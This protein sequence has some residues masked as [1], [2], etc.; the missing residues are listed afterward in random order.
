MSP[1]WCHSDQ[2]HPWIRRSFR[3]FNLPF[4]TGGFRK[5]WGHILY[6]RLDWT[7]RMSQGG[8][9][10]Q[11]KDRQ[12]RLS[13]LPLVQALWHFVSVSF[14]KARRT[15]G[16]PSLYWMKLHVGYNNYLLP[17]W[18]FHSRYILKLQVFIYIIFFAYSGN[19]NKIDLD[20]TS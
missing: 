11:S 7:R 18:Y 9:L 19:P 13:A 6:L 20:K 3:I 1:D 8:N 4:S 12:G 10:D 17:L 15:I 14:D 5:H 16:T 2:C